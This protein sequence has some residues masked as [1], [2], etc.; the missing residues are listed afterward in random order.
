MIDYLCRQRKV[1]PVQLQL[2]GEDQIAA[3]NETKDLIE[4]LAKLKYEL[5]TNKPFVEL[6]SN[7]EDTKLW[8]DCLR[9]E[10]ERTKDVTWF[11]VSWLYAECYVYRRIREIFYCSKYYQRFDPFDHNKKESF[12]NS[13]D[14]VIRLTAQLEL[15][16]KNLESQSLKD[17][18]HAFL[19]VN[20]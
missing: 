11:N 2:K 7:L 5:T 3:E 6:N 8:N 9:T 20:N 1:L 16:E 19:M 4:K 10:L 15:T 17:L 14:E 18:F 12:Q 13:K